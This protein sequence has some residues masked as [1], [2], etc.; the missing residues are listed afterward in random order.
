MSTEPH[1]TSALP[2]VKV[3]PRPVR[4]AGRSVIVCDDEY[5]CVIANAMFS[6][7]SVTMN[8]GSLMRVTSRPLSRPNSVVTPM[9]HRMATGT[10]MP[11]SVANFVMMIPPSAI[12]MPHDRSM[13]AVRMIS[14]WPMAITPTTITC[15]RISDR[16]PPVRKRSDCVA[17]KMQAPSRASHGPRAPHGMWCVGDFAI[18]VPPYRPGP[19]TSCPSTARCRSWCPCCRRRPRSCRR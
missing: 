8:G 7:P 2:M 5:S 16:L 3:V 19:F 13:P 15:C 1:A 9:P 17:K 14:V 12:T 18:G 6:V 4:P 11:S 10:G